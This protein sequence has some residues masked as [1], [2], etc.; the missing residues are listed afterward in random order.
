MKQN[1]LVVLLSFYLVV[2]GHAQTFRGS[3][4][5]HSDG[6][7]QEPALAWHSQSDR[8]LQRTSITRQLRPAMVNTLFQDCP[9]NV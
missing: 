9:S 5:R 6:I 2:A 8:R 4:Q 1:M 7:L 3:N